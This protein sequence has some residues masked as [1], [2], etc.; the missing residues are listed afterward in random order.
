MNYII[1]YDIKE[2]KIRNGVFK[3]LRYF[4]FVN[5][6]KSIFLGRD[7]NNK[8]LGLTLNFFKKQKIDS[9]FIA[10]IDINNLST[11][12]KGLLLE[13]DEII[14]IWLNKFKDLYLLVIGNEYLF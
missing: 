12:I 5:I 3:E 9:Y 2:D 7:I 6:Q 14:V 1:G 11:N 13:E 8:V 10:K 4:R